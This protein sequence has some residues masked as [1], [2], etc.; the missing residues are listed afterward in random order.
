MESFLH[1][2]WKVGLSLTLGW[3]PAL[4]LALVLLAI[5]LAWGWRWW[6]LAA[7][8][9][10]PLL[11]LVGWAL[12]SAS[13]PLVPPAQQQG[14]L[15]IA[16]LNALFYFN[17]PVGPKLKF[18]E[19]ANADVVSVVEANPAL[20][21]AAQSISATYPFQ[22][23]TTGGTLPMLLLAKHPITQAQKFNPRMV[24]YHIK[25]PGAAFYVLQWHPQS[26]YT[27]AAMAERDA[28]LT[29]F[30]TQLPLLPR[31]LVVVGDINAV[32]W[33]KALQPLREQLTLAG[34]WRAYLP[35]FP[36]WA[37]LAPIDHL[38]VSPQFTTLKLQQARVP[39]TDH[40]GMVADFQL[41]P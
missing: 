16:H 2:V 17:T 12:W 11:V 39:G 19:G 5:M 36:R 18:I 7:F 10:A 13:L 25:R 24:L 32:P 1:W 31:P 37:P 29:A 41:L 21:Q 30:A 6:S 33:D 3:A 28:A 20:V 8:P 15:R 26:P 34:G 40:L 9:I 27:P 23:A 35:T 38:L 22:Q 14:N 4:L